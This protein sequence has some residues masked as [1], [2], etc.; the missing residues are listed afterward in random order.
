MKIKAFNP[1][2]G[3]NAKAHR[4]E[5]NFM[6]E[7]SLIVNTKDYNGKP[8]ISS[9]AVVRIYGTKAMNY[10]CIWVNDRKT[11]TYCSGSGSAGGYGYHRPSAAAA[12][13][14]KSMGVELSENID[15][16]GDSAIVEAIE[17]LGRRL[18]YRK[19]YI[20]KAHA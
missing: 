9:V 11:G 6:E 20:H 10:C 18:G 3:I 4:K 13:A 14:F 1:V 16:R 2:N 12:Y 15:G 17:A 19:F 7:F 5:S 8:S